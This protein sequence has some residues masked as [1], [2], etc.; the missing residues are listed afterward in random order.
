MRTS[1]CCAA[2]ACVVSLA[3]ASYAD[4]VFMD[5][6]DGAGGPLNGTTPDVSLGGEVWEA[7][8]TFL[9][10]GAAGTTVA[11]GP[12]GQAAHLDFTPLIGVYTAE[13]TILNDQPNWIGFGFLPDDPGSGDWTQTDFSVRHSNAPGF[14]WM[15][16]RNSTGNDQEGF[17]GGGTAGGQPWNGDVV[18]PTAPV[19]M[20]IVLDTTPTNWTVEWFINGTSMGA[21]VAYGTAGNPGIGG[22]GFSHDRSSDANNG[23]TLSEFSL[24]YVPEPTSLLLIGFGGLALIRRR[25]PDTD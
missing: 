6:F 2:L 8:D 25:Y 10:N 12:T 14:A 11:G 23:G 13:A 17:L 18:D 20:K 24:T 3:V 9:D 5:N 19:I 7:G 4:V 16:T 22:I 15:L 1:L 21:P